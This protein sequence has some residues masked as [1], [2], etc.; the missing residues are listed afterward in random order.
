MG[1]L[2]LRGNCLNSYIKPGIGCKYRRWVDV[3]LTQPMHQRS[4]LA[5]PTRT[6]LQN[7]AKSSQVAVTSSK[8]YAL[9]ITQQKIM[10]QLAAFQTASAQVI[11]LSVCAVHTKW[12]LQLTSCVIDLL[13]Q[14][15]DKLGSIHSVRYAAICCELAIPCKKFLAIPCTVARQEKQGTGSC[16]SSPL[17]SP[18]CMSPLDCV[19]SVCG[20]TIWSD[21]A[22]MYVF[23]VKVM[24]LPVG[25]A[26]RF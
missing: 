19:C 3:S 25:P 17:T 14:V 1:N 24:C 22:L 13:V 6:Q 21:T 5:A 26:V 16:R 20:P 12:R 15:S 11:S 9:W 18:E 7:Q 10:A 4:A 2:T 8:S 23:G